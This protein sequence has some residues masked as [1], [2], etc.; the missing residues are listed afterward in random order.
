MHKSLVRMG[1]HPKDVDR[2]LTFVNSLVEAMDWLCLNV[3]EDNLPK[4]F[5]PTKGNIQVKLFAKPAAIEAPPQVIL[6]QFN[7]E[8]Y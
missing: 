5:A 6:V 3:N 4:K 1:F 8:S 2:A 7:L